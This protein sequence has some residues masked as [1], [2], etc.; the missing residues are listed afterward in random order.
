MEIAL[1]GSTL[2]YHK[3]GSGS[4]NMLLFHGFGQD[5]TVFFPLI[6]SLKEDYTC[7]AFD[8]FFHGNSKRTER[9]ITIEKHE[10]KKLVEAFISREN[11]NSFSILGFSIGGRLAL[12]TF[13]DFPKRTENLI[14]VAAEG[15]RK[16][17]WYSWATHRKLGQPVFRGFVNKPKVF[18]AVLKIAKALH[19][20]P[21]PL[22]K[23]VS[24]QMDSA[25][26]RHRVFA[27]WISL[28]KLSLSVKQFI[29]LSSFHTGRI[30]FIF[31][32]DDDIMRKAVSDHLQKR[33]SNAEF[34]FLDARHHQ[35]LKRLPECLPVWI[36][37]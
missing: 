12:A 20:L 35:L 27:S 25:E 6:E 11:L 33:I 16:N 24:K 36:K 23:F 18:F 31:G 9:D 37:T 21:Q 30:I 7:Y 3:A 28:R 34:K 13:E 10:W 19:L 8:L 2:F 29:D 15:L 32:I 26:K 4:K 14:L 1:E 17:F 5:H 22:F